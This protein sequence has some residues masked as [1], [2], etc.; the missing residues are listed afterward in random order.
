MEAL[1]QFLEKQLNK[2]ITS[3]V[4]LQGGDINEAVRLNTE[5]DQYFLKWNDANTY[6]NMLQ[7]EAAG[8]N[9]LR[10]QSSLVV[11]GVISQGLAGNRQWLILEWLEKQPVTS[12]SLREFGRKLAGLHTCRQ[13]FFG[14][15][16][17][18][19]IGNLKQLNKARESWAAFYADCRI[20]PLVSNLVDS[21]RFTSADARL[22]ESFCTKLGDLMP[23]E[24]PALL[25]GDLW[26]GNYMIVENGAAV[27][28]PAVY[29]G[30]REMDIGMTRLFGGFDDS[31]YAGYE[32]IYPLE[33]GWEQRL[34]ITQLYPLLVHAVL[35]GGHYTENCRKLLRN[36]A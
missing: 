4:N 36:L 13:P 21:G 22:A 7:L 3:Y 6:P 30:H 9:V 34:A 23:A 15:Q 27:F 32:E 19:F 10:D 12:D 5:N 8:L 26:S 29:Y 24:P 28:D 11:P 17:D 35:F 33:K 1:T 16:T 25:H 18:N 2:A 14:W 20:L 31:F